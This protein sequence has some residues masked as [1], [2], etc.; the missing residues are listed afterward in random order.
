MKVLLFSNLFPIPREPS[1]GVFVAQLA[2]ALQAHATVHALVPLPWVPRSATLRGVLPHA[3]RVFQD[4]PASLQWRGV[5]ASIVRYPMIPG[6]GRRRQ[7]SFMAR[8]ARSTAERLHRTIGFDLVNAHWLDPDGIAAAEI[9]RDLNLPLVLSARGCDVNLNL[10]LP[11]LRERLLT[12][13]QA[14]AAV[15]TVSPQLRAALVQAGVQADHVT[16]IPNGV[17]TARFFVRS[18]AAARA[19]LELPREARLI[20]C[21]SRLSEEKGVDV[22]VEAMAHPAVAARGA[23]LM[24]VGD[25]PMREALTARV[26]SLGIASAVRFVGAVSHDSA[27]EWFAAADVCCLPSL[28]EGYPNVV[29]EAL[30][31]GRP[32]VASKVGAI[33]DMLSDASGILVPAGNSDALGLALGEA[34]GREWDEGAIAASVEGMSWPR[35]AQAY[36]DV[37]RRVVEAPRPT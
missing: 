10:T 26:A 7:A 25:G 33:P 4:V 21:V 9:A 20:V 8:A 14:A 37:Y 23:T 29:L 15:T 11:F 3:A 17:D 5:D 22:L 28:R 36:L 32:M 35:A 31:C 34:L 6:M 16:A 12:A 19:A 24:L 27:A 18:R 2:Q 30:A 1:R 13:V